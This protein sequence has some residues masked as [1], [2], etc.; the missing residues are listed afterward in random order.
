ML[1]RSVA[2]HGRAEA[3]PTGRAQ[4]DHP[5]TAVEPLQYVG[6]G[7]PGRCVG[8]VIDHDHLDVA[9]RL[10]TYGRKCP[11]QQ[12]VPVAR[13]DDDRNTA[14]GMRIAARQK[15]VFKWS[16]SIAGCQFFAFGALDC[17]RPGPQTESCHPNTPFCVHTEVPFY[18]TPGFRAWHES[19]ACGQI[20][21]LA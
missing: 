1:F 6:I 10:R 16:D 5:K 8:T 14:S 7:L 21:Y 2:R 3:R 15:A 9:E 4:F 11:F 13:W 19:V 20:A 12:G 18:Q 17:G